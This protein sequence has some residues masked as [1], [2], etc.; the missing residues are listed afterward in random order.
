MEDVQNVECRMQNV[1]KSEIRNGK[2][3]TD[4]CKPP[5]PRRLPTR[6]SP[7]G[8]LLFVL[9]FELCLSPVL[10]CERPLANE[11]GLR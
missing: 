3:T 6:P 11:R 5:S 8:R 4:Y 7:R 2:M 9:H 10:F 1:R